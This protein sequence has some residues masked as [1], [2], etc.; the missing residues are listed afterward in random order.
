MDWNEF[1]HEAVAEK[2]AELV[3]QALA[4]G[5]DSNSPEA[6]G[7]SFSSFVGTT[8]LFWAVGGET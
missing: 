8:E 1:L 3:R 6:P 5:A 7:D 2:D 4:Q